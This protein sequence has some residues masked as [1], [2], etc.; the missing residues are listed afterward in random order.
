MRMER[1]VE[2]KIYKELGI[3]VWLSKEWEYMRKIHLTIA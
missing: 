3:L 2:S 1:I